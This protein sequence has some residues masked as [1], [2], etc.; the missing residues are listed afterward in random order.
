[1][2]LPDCLSTSLGHATKKTRLAPAIYIVCE[3]V[4]VC[5]KWA[6]K[7]A[8]VAVPCRQG[9]G[10]AA[11]AVQLVRTN[12]GALQRRVPRGPRERTI[13]RERARKLV[14][15]RLTLEIKVNATRVGYASSDTMM[16]TRPAGQHQCVRHQPNS[17]RRHMARIAQIEPSGS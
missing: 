17:S 11:R 8:S 1:M 6:P 7:K 10:V 4:S 16:P 9:D 2:C 12:A 13:N 3:C 15:H 5:V 14:R